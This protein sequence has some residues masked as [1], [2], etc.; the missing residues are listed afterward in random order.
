[1]TAIT[2][3]EKTKRTRLIVGLIVLAILIAFPFIVPRPQFWVVSI[4]IRSLWLGIVALSLTWLAKYSGMVSLG[5]LT[6]WGVSAYT[7]AVMSTSN[8]VPY[9]VSIPTGLLLGTLVGF[10]VA[11][12]CVRT[13]GIYLLM[14]TLAVSQ[15]GYFLALNASG[16]TRGFQGIGNIQRPELFGMSLGNRNVFY[17]LALAIAIGLYLLC[18]YIARTPFGL[19]LEGIRD[20]PERMAALGYNVYWYRVGAFTFSAFLASVSGVLAL[21]YQGRITPGTV[22]LM[23]SVDILI[24]SVLGGLNSIVGAFVGATSLTLIQNFSQESWVPFGRLTLTGL[25]FVAVLLFMPGGLVSLFEKIRDLILRQF[26]RKGSGD[27]TPSPTD[28]PLDVAS[29]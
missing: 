18:R 29:G 24:V 1:M 6:F 25:I 27:G 4:G 19:A 20:S 8:D 12:I 13:Q 3:P 9:L 17:F 5:Q 28:S 2:T 10:I 26:G 15:L 22:D 23:R 21:F 7:V 16:I 14:L 11:V